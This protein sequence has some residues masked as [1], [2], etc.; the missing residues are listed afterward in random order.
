MSYVGTTVTSR[1]DSRYGLV[2]VVDVLAHDRMFMSD[3]DERRLTRWVTVFDTQVCDPVWHIL[4]VPDSFPAGSLS[5]SQCAELLS[6]QYGN[7]RREPNMKDLDLF[8]RFAWDESA[9]VASEVQ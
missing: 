1:I 2:C 4:M 7:D 9:E 8:E 5:F 6:V 3:G